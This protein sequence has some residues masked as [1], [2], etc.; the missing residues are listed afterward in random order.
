MK[1]LL[2][3]AFRNI[4]RN[5][6]QTAL[7]VAIVALGTW[8]MV[9]TWG[10]I[11]GTTDSMLHAQITL[12]TGQIQIHRAGYLD[13]PDL[14]NLLSA[15]EVETLKAT[16]SKDTRIEHISPRLV[17]EGLLKSA[18]GTAGVGI[19]GIE[20]EAEAQLTDLPQTVVEGHFLNAPGQILL[21]RSLAQKLDV[22]LGERVVLQAQGLRRTRSQ[23]FRLVGILNTGLARLDQATAFVHL[24]DVE[25]LAQVEGVSELALTLVPRENAQRLSDTLQ[26]AFGE[27]VE[28][29]S[30]F[31]LNPLIA[32]IVNLSLVRIGII[33]VLLSTLAG[34]GVANT[35]TFTVLKRIREFG[36]V[37]ALGLRPKQ[38][39]RLIT[40]EALLISTL[41]F[42]MGA[43]LGYSLSIYLEHVGID[44]GFYSDSFPDIGAPRVIYAKALWS[45]GFYSLL[46]VLLT[47][48]IAART[49]ARR[50][51]HL[52][53][54][55]AM[56]YV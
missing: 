31:D 13:N 11:D 38:L 54:T 7:M 9:V 21:G 1:V 22:R 35:I 24:K 55:E 3:L 52:E 37:L 28:V 32:V 42:V 27:D 33:M 15:T 5:R 48:V 10:V 17:T 6:R 56:R 19:R 16:L 20:P 34:F 36:V 8:A 26:A 12:D 43:L 46:V 47:A 4:V 2:K 53:P 29:S 39:S 30:F 51:A 49:P 45:H 23:G 41:G 44:F 40:L 50:A 18:Y 25:A 14:G